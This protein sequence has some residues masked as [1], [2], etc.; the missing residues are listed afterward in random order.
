MQDNEA[1]TLQGQWDRVERQRKTISEKL[2]KSKDNYFE[3]K[4][5]LRF[6]E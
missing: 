5:G 3:V 4:E 2:R 6:V 1:K